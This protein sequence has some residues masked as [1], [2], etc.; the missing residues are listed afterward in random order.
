M[1][2]FPSLRSGLLALAASAVVATASAQ[3]M[4]T[5]TGNYD[6]YGTQTLG[7]FIAGSLPDFAYHNYFVFDR[8]D[9]AFPVSPIT[10]ATLQFTL[11]D[12]LFAPTYFSSD[13]ND[14]GALFSV[15][16]YSGS[17]SDL[18][19]GTGD[20]SALTSGSLFGSRMVSA[21]DNVDGGVIS[22]ELNADF[23][24]FINGGGSGL[25]A[26]G[27]GLSNPND[28]PTVDDIEYLFGSSGFG[29]TVSLQ[30][31]T[32]AVPEPSTYGLIGAGALGLL[33]WRRRSV[34]AVRKS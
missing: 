7:N 30:L 23:L 9:A 34:K 1:L 17:I 14:T 8:S 6:N 13:V 31:E 29:T 19:G 15:Y 12:P 27:G 10:K 4:P 24:S 33:I 26:F 32:S 18:T 21:A 5:E 16:N 28:T 22:I 11:L 3:I 2:K 25:F 20:F